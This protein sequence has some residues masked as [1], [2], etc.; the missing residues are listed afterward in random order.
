[1][2]QR[3]FTFL[4]TNMRHRSIWIAAPVAFSLLAVS[5]TADAGDKQAVK[6]VNAP[7]AIGPYSQGV[8][9]GDTVYLSGQ[10]AFDPKTNQAMSDASIEDQTRQALENLKAVLEASGMTMDDI[11]STTVYLT[12][13]GEFSK[14][15]SVYAT[16]FKE[17]PPARA[18]VEVSKL[19]R[20]LKVEI[21]A[22]A[23]K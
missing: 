21:S 2:A 5:A 22:I 23:R 20:N 11:V 7:A 19:P 13:I 14:M 18:T 10:G 1:M 8:R 4:G 17:V 3:A 9:F 12:D 15:N 6:S 16:F